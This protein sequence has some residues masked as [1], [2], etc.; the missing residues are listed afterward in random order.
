MRFYGSRP[1]GVAIFKMGDGSYR[2]ARSVPGLTEGSGGPVPVMEPWP[3]IPE[4][5]SD[6]SG[7]I[8]VVNDAVAW[9]WVYGQ[10]TKYPLD[11]PTVQVVYQ[12]GHTYTVDAEETADLAAAGFGPYLS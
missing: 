8:G 1:V 5:A 10:G 2:S 11:Q 7:G 12:G 3:A 6:A 9:S 4:I